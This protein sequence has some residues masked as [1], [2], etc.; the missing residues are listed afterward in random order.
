MN[1]RE[2]S[3]KKTLLNDHS[4]NKKHIVATDINAWMETHQKKKSS[5]KQYHEPLVNNKRSNTLL[6]VNRSQKLMQSLEQTRDLSKDRREDV[7]IKASEKMMAK[8][9]NENL[10]R[11]GSELLKEVCL[12]TIE[13]PSFKIRRRCN[14][15]GYVLK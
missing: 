7:E 13:Q 4:T 10:T 8:R 3:I 14:S 11:N 15:K 9:H 5:L 12:N 6:P 1:T 2:N